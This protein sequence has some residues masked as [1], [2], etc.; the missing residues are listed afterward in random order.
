VSPSWSDQG[1]GLW[2]ARKLVEKMGGE[3]MVSHTVVESDSLVFSFRVAFDRET[4]SEGS[5]PDANDGVGPSPR[6]GLGDFIM[7]PNVLIVDALS[8]LRATLRKYVEAW[9]FRARDVD[10]LQEA[11][12]ELNLRYYTVVL[13]NLQTKTMSKTMSGIHSP[14]QT[15]GFTG[16]SHAMQ[17]EGYNQVRLSPSVRRE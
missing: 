3:V 5:T 11:R 12:E 16:S 14:A 15:S 2:L 4:L 6:V 7:K 1:F 10:S 17:A 13:I 9:G 8:P